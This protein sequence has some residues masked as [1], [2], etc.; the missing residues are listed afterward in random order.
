MILGLIAFVD[1]L[2]YAIYDGEN[3]IGPVVALGC[4]LFWVFGLLQLTW[5]KL[6]FVS[7]S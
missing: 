5:A 4:S 1:T 7:R 3:P 2:R 6:A